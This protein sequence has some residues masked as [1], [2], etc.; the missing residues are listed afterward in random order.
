MDIDPEMNTDFDENSQFQEGI[1]SEMYQR[2][3]KSYFQEP[4]ELKGLINK[5]RL[6]QKVL[7]KQA[8][9]DKKLKIIQRKVLKRNTLTFY[10]KEI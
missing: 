4:Q 5:G 7:P 9:I 3:H 2:P 6:I 1:V 8:D 10:C